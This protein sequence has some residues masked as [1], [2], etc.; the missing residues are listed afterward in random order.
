MRDGTKSCKI[1][2]ELGSVRADVDLKP[3]SPSLGE[4]PCTEMW[5]WWVNPFPHSAHGRGPPSLRAAAQ[6]GLCLGGLWGWE[7]T[8]SRTQGGTGS[9]WG[10]S[11]EHGGRFLLSCT[12][13]WRVPCVS[14]VS[15]PCC[16]PRAMLSHNGRLDLPPIDVFVHGIITAFKQQFLCCVR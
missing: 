5:V 10:I 16:A 11:G 13:S 7:G 14:C 8:V 3:T 6:W 4:V 9:G 15:V 1:P 2:G 12:T